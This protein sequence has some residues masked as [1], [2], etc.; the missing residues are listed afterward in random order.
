MVLVHAASTMMFK[1]SINSSRNLQTSLISVSHTM[2]REN[3]MKADLGKIFHTE[4]C[5]R[6][7]VRRPVEFKDSSLSHIRH[8]ITLLHCPLHYITCGSD[9][10]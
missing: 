8:N 3:L 4:M 2:Q 9:I 10:Q 1:A 5:E 7:T 6:L